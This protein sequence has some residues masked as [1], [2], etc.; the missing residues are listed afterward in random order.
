MIYQCALP[1]KDVNVLTSHIWIVMK[2]QYSW[3]SYWAMMM[4]NIQGLEPIT[5]NYLWWLIKTLK[6]FQKGLYLSTE[7][8][9]VRSVPSHIGKVVSLTYSWDWRIQC[10]YHKRVPTTS[11]SSLTMLP[12]YEYKLVNSH[13]F[14]VHVLVLPW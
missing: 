8:T 14:C 12:T 5:Y 10:I 7:W 2:G 13:G 4:I 1:C 6:T 9:R 11:P 3:N